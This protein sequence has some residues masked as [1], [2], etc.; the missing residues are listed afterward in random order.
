M[1]TALENEPVGLE[2]LAKAICKYDFPRHF[3]E[4]AE[5]L[6]RYPRVLL[7][8]SRDHGKSTFLSKIY[9]ITQVVARP[10]V[11]ILIVSYSENQVMK[12]ITGIKDQ[13]E[14]QDC[15]KTL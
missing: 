2:A 7:V 11:E 14:K 3:R 5:L 12:L 15:I 9:P 13:F 10:G 6:Y 4:W 1:I 8:A